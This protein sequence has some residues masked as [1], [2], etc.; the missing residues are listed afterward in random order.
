MVADGD[1]L[2]MRVNVKGTKSWIFSYRLAGE[3]NTKNYRIGKHP[4]FSLQEAREERD[5]L[6]KLVSR[7]IDPKQQ[8][9]ADSEA[10]AGI[11]TLRELAPLWLDRYAH[12]RQLKQKSIDG[13]NDRFGLHIYPALG[14]LRVT[15]ITPRLLLD[16]LDYLQQDDKLDTLK[17]CVG[18]VAKIM[19]MAVSRQYIAYNPV[20]PIKDEFKKPIHK[21]WASIKPNDMPEFYARLD[22]YAKMLASTRLLIDLLILTA[23]RVEALVTLEWSFI[24]WEAKLLTIPKE[25]MKGVRRSIEAR[26]DHTVPLSKQSIRLFKNLYNMNGGSRYCFASRGKSG[27]CGK[28]LAN[29]TL[30]KMGVA[31]TAHG[32]RTTFSTHCYESRLWTGDA[33][34]LQL[35]HKVSENEARTT[36]DKSLLLDERRGLMQWWADENDKWKMARPSGLEPKSTA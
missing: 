29:S 21:N 36:Y 7:G 32:F 6:R 14:D 10:Q 8:A 3:K 23:L 24:D 20:L 17:R 1:G 4:D 34:E 16:K 11:P 22:G 31:E 28:S 12:N 25:N 27:H 35:A 30:S 13:Y 15:D 5:K 18:T 26:V 19:D 9:R 2:S 33:I